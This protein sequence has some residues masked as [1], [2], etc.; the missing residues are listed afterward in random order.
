[1]ERGNV[2]DRL[3]GK[4]GLIHTPGK[5]AMKGF[6]ER[7]RI[8]QEQGRTA[9]QAAVMAAIKKFQ[10]EF[11]PTRYYYHGEP[12]ETLLAIIEKL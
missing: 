2:A 4:L 12:I 6:A 8:L 5:D 11:Q 3:T 1:M 7:V 9:D 10:A